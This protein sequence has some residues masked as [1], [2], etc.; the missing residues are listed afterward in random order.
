MA[1]SPQITHISWGRME[2]EGLAPGKDFKLYPGGGRPWDWSEHGTRHSPGIQP[3]DVQE[4][5]DHGS[6]VIVLS[7]GMELRLQTMPETLSL[8][9]ANGIEVHIQETT[10]AVTLYNTLAQTTAVGGLF[11]STC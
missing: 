2:V 1:A 5:L 4:L 10:A 7:R 3:A 6:M 11:H 8:L 9:E